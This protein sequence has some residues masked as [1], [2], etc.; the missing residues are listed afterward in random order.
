M[1]RQGTRDASGAVGL[2]LQ[3]EEDHEVAGRCG[4]GHRDRRQ[5]S[6]GH[7]YGGRH[8]R[9][10]RKGRGTHEDDDGLSEQEDRHADSE[11]STAL[12][13]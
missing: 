12:D 6:I 4:G 1:A 7:S 8:D 13:S 2:C 3:T 9:C 5:T 11:E 10:G